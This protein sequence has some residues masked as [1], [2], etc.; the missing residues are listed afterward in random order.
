MRL[1]TALRHLLPT[2]LLVGL[3]LAMS[4]A[5][6]WR[7]GEAVLLDAWF[8]LRGPVPATG[9]VVLVLIDDESI[10]RLGG[11]PLTR[12]NLAR[13]VEHLDEAGAQVIA[14]D[15]LLTEPGRVERDHGF[16]PDDDSGEAVGQV[17]DRYLLQDDRD[18]RLITA[19]AAHGNVLLP[20]A[21]VFDPAQANRAGLPAT[22]WRHAY[23]V[24]RIPGGWIG[25]LPLPV[26]VLGPADPL[27]DAAHALGHVTAIVDAD[28]HLRTDY[29]TI[30]FDGLYY[31]SLAV[32][33]A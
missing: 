33:I 12:Q 19:M 27:V 26:G 6:L 1:A 13:L 28:G 8:R 16:T 11:W 2:L 29:T 25:H 7:S 22:Y 23:S 21:F 15:L 10:R 4:G 18:G 3:T 20:F 30:G 9:E 31:P 14:F 5:S 32:E 24:V 17:I